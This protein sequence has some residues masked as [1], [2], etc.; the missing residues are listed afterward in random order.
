VL[1]SYSGARPG[2]AQDIATLANLTGNSNQ[3]N[4]NRAAF[5]GAVSKP[6]ELS[7]YSDSQIANIAAQQ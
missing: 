7:R 3:R 6:R 5:F 2:V 4:F 1:G